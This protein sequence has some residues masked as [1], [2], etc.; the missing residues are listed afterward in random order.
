MRKSSVRTSLIAAICLLAPGMVVT[1]ASASAGAVSSIVHTLDPGVPPS[2]PGV[3]PGKP[4]PGETFEVRGEIN[5]TGERPVLLEK[6]SS[7]A[8]STVKTASTL[9]DGHYSFFTTITSKTTFRVRGP[10]TA[11]EA[12]SVT[13]S[14]SVYVGT[15]A[16]SLSITRDCVTATDCSTTT[17]TAIGT[18]S[19]IRAGRLVA[20]QRQSG[21]TWTQLGS[22]VAED[23]SGKAQF[24]FSLSGMSKWSSSPYRLVVSSFNGSGTVTSPT[25]K[26]M[27]GPTTL[28]DN[29][30]R[31]TTKK[32]VAVTSK[33]TNYPG[34]ASFTTN[35]VTEGPYLTETLSLHGNST[36]SLEKKPY[37]LKFIDK[38]KLF[39]MK[40]DRTWLLLAH[41]IDPSGVRDKVGL[42]LGNKLSANLKWTPQ[43][44]YAE[45]FVNDEY[46]GNYLV[47]ESIKIDK[48]RVNVDKAKGIVVTIDGRSV[49]SGGYGFISSHNIPIIF[50]D[51]D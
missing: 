3:V 33:S 25:I 46:M 49:P 41:F 1:T 21:S 50:K 28:G 34:S 42:D 43:N 48:N 23:A 10:A 32:N 44:K 2:A 4:L 39:G 13:P 40:N 37:K 6:F 27:P 16:V 12:E 26:F 8:W 51:P 15:D 45:V 19:P 47:T 18:L 24:S 14:K 5:A 29:V 36:A 17:A 35:G 30:L 11:T 9:A 22:K 7:S 31:V 38:Q 20:L